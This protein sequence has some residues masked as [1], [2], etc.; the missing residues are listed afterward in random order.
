MINDLINKILFKM[1]R[2]VKDDVLE[3]LKMK[4]ISVDKLTA[5]PAKPQLAK[6]LDSVP[7]A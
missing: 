2:A 1:I 6:D 3:K 4:R 5:R 7:Q